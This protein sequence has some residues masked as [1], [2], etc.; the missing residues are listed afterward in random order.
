MFYNDEHVIYTQCARIDPV[1]AILC[2]IAPYTFHCRII[3]I[4]PP[5]KERKEALHCTWL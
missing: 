3:D 1:S 4:E 2:S 5:K